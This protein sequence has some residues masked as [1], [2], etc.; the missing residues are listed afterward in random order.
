MTCGVTGEAA[1]AT[2]KTDVP[3]EVTLAEVS[4]LPCHAA[5][6]PHCHT[7]QVAHGRRMHA[8]ASRAPPRLLPACLPVCRMLCP[9][10]TA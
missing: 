1:A 5:T 6:L 3:L 2:G 10:A 8:G 4:T 9:V 7:R